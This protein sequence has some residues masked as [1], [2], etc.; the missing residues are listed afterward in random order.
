MSKNNNNFSDLKRLLKLKQHEIPPPGYFNHFSGDVVS[1]IRAGE[2]GGG[3]GFLEQLQSNSPLVS[4]LLQLFGVRPGIMG[5]LAT[6]VCLLLLVGVL[7]LDR[8]ESG[9]VS[10]PTAF[11]QSEPMATEG[12]PTLVASA[13]T[14][15]PPDSGI[16]ISTNPVSSL[17]PVNTLFGSP[18][19]PLFQSVTFVPAR[20]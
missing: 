19:N 8:S 4:A 14:L 3:R 10:G 11:A 5:G 9:P 17:Q 1:R 12:S 16:T 15:A 7:F 6:S 13:D 18:Q 2:S 20:Q